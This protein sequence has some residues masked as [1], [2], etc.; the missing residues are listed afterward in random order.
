MDKKTYSSYYTNLIKN[1]SK[2]REKDDKELEENDLFIDFDEEREEVYVLLWK[3]LYIFDRKGY[4]IF[5][6]LWSKGVLTPNKGGYL[7]VKDKEWNELIR[8]HNHL[9][10][11]EIE[12]LSKKLNCPTKDIHVHHKSGVYDKNGKYDNRLNNLEVLHKDE[13]AK[14]HGKETWEKY[15]NWR[16]ENGIK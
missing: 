14:R 5:Q 11:E 15:Q 1:L 4:K 3:K 10:R 16:K 12:K 8:I 6:D 9:K 7:C 13:H 2:L